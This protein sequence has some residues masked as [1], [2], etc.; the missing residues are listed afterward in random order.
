[1]VYTYTY[2]RMW[3]IVSLVLVIYCV[4]AYINL[5]VETQ[6]R[7]VFAKSCVYIYSILYQSVNR[8]Q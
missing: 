7:C 3:L 4:V 8:I 5:Y 2:I 6:C 1:M